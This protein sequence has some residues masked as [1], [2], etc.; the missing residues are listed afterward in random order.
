MLQ[1]HA[2]VVDHRAEPDTVN[3]AHESAGSGNAQVE[4]SL[5]G[6]YLQPAQERLGRCPIAR[7]VLMHRRLVLQSTG[8]WRACGSGPV[9]RAKLRGL[10]SVGHVLTLAPSACQDSVLPSYPM[11]ELDGL[12]VDGMQMKTGRTPWGDPCPRCGASRSAPDERDRTC[13]C[14][15][16]PVCLEPTLCACAYCGR[17]L[18][19]KDHGTGM[20]R[21]VETYCLATP[22][23]RAG[24]DAV[25]ASGDNVD[26]KV[27]A[28][29]I[30]AMAPRPWPMPSPPWG[31]R[32]DR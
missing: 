16:C 32:W 28:A 25:V 1:W 4:G 7:V 26:V 23:Q 3:S 22:E 5:A 17:S 11:E 9:E 12:L 31:S 29:G 6:V 18:G 27:F 10:A 2:L 24:F 20:T 21:H 14:E 19:C 8:L 30:Q 15:P 13:V